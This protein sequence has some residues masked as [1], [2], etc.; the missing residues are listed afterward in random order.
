[1]GEVMAVTLADNYKNLGNLAQ[2]TK[3]ELQNIEGIGPNIAQAIVDWFD[4]A[5]NRILINRLQENGVWPVVE[6]PTTADGKFS[7]ALSGMTFV[8]TGTLP[9][10]SREEMKNLIQSNGGKVVDSVSKNTNWLLAGENAGSKLAKANSL[11][12]QVIDE[13]SLLKMLKMKQP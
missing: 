11:G 9:N 6:S 2:A 1:M 7:T 4:R 3:D 12:V 8:I 13:D 5:A 10:Y